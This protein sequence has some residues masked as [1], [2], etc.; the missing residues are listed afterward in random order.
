MYV[1]EKLQRQTFEALAPQVPGGHFLMFIS[2]IYILL[3]FEVLEVSLLTNLVS[4]MK[5]CVLSW[6]LR[7]G[8]S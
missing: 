5:A 7:D 4:R 1:G 6:S 2:Y 3:T 8:I